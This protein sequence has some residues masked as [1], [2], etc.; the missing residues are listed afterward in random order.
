MEGQLIILIILSFGNI[1]YILVSSTWFY[2]S[3][4]TCSRRLYQPSIIPIGRGDYHWRRSGHNIMLKLKRKAR[5]SQMA[6]NKCQTYCSSFNVNF[7][8][9]Y[10]DCHHFHRYS[11]CR[12]PWRWWGV[13]CLTGSVSLLHVNQ[14][15]SSLVLYF[16]VSPHTNT[17]TKRD[18]YDG[19]IEWNE[20]T[21]QSPSTFG[22]IQKECAMWLSRILADRSLN[23]IHPSMRQQLT[24]DGSGWFALPTQYV[25]RV[26]SKIYSLKRL[27]TDWLS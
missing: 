20:S 17:P 9:I 24:R 15:L 10:D 6:A 26:L 5:Q 22:T 2:C 19:M 8:I 7:V 18:C 23:P 16:M 27:L 4:W 1:L 25:I 21:Q 13:P 12:C 14:F 11:C 3:R